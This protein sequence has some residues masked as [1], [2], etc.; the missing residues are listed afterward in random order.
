M[1]QFKN[2]HLR[3]ELIT[4]AFRSFR[5]SSQVEVLEYEKLTRYIVSPPEV[6][7]TCKICYYQNDNKGTVSFS[8]H[9][10]IDNEELAKE[11]VEHVINRTRF[12]SQ[13]SRSIYIED[14]SEENLNDLVEYLV[15]EYDVEEVEKKNR[16]NG[17]T[18][19]LKSAYGDKCHL[20][21]FTNRAFN[22]QGK[23]GLL[24]SF[25][26]E[27]LSQYLSFGDIVEATLEGY[28]VENVDR[29]EVGVMFEARIPTAKDY[30]HDVV[31]AVLM[32]AIITERI[33]VETTDYSFIT[34]PA[35]RGLEAF[36]KQIFNDSGIP[37]NENFGEKFGY[38]NTTGKY[39]VS[40]N[41]KNAL[42]CEYKQAVVEKCYNHF[43]GTRHLIFHTTGILVGTSLI[44]DID[45]AKSHVS[46][47]FDLIENSVR[48]I[49]ERNTALL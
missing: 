40:E 7:S 42:N 39:V 22:V 36:M 3:R 20:N 29:D 13:N 43:K 21:Y 38:D 17:Y 4:D 27:G 28:K 18:I 19:T 2:L 30:I 33:D 23:S 32:P 1:T 24:K 37:I 26:L 41:A 46:D 14:F 12:D 34:F 16:T 5:E 10:S 15:S 35:F 48:C 31:K 44:E 11:I 45:E 6:D 25:V 9:E 49:Q 8:L 47:V